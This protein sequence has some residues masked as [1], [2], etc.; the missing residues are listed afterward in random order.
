MK[1][2]PSTRKA[3]GI[4]KAIELM[5]RPE[6]RL[7]KMHTSGSPNGIAHYLIPG[8]YVE[9]DVAEKIKAHPLVCAGEDGLF[10]NCGQTWRLR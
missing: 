2:A 3:I 1:A 6:T 5:R 9:P 8:G 7:V 4:K 10:P